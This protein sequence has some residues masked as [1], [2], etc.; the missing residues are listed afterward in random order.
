MNIS[1]IIIGI[2]KETVLPNFQ[3][4]QY[5]RSDVASKQLSSTGV[6]EKVVAICTEKL[7]EKSIEKDCTP[8]KATDLRASL[9]AF[10]LGEIITSFHTTLFNYPNFMY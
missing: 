8:V 7:E 5:I 6:S 1:S 4:L 9:Q 10:G 3:A 2:V